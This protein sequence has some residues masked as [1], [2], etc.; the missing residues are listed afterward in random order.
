MTSGGV[1]AGAPQVRR[2]RLVWGV[3]VAAYVVTLFERYSLGVASL[4]AR[5]RFG[6]GAS[7]LAGFV[8]LQFVIYAALQ[9]PVGVVLDRYGPKRL[10][11][12]GLVL[13]TVAQAAFAFAARA[14]AAV[15]SRVVL[16]AGDALI[17]I[18]VIR[19]VASWFPPRRNPFM[20][21][22]T[23][24]LGQ[25]GAVAAATPL[26]LL[27]RTVGWRAT[28]LIASAL[29]ALVAVT[30]QLALRDT[31]AGTTR[32]RSPAPTGHVREL[33]SSAWREPGTRPACGPISPRSSPG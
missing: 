21:Q 30:A 4:Q 18:S 5:D 2:R 14:D 11:V 16:G 15:A 8:V 31:P 7:V 10:I 22:V 23:G 25:L 26:L 32:R 3:G 28:F 9:V 13:L 19:L 20:V 17:F 24:V 6:V 12:L 33:L 29:A 27:L 1:G